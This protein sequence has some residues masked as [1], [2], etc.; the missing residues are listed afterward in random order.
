MSNVTTERSWRAAIYGAGAIFSVCLILLITNQGVL[1]GE[2]I[3][4][5]KE[6]DGSYTDTGG[7]NIPTNLIA[8]RSTFCNYFTG[9]GVV[10]VIKPDNFAQCPLIGDLSK[11]A[12][13]D[14]HGA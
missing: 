14:P 6:W 7:I 5:E 11:G 9:R 1:V 10:S 4:V 3:P 13:E 8:G 2:D 12:C